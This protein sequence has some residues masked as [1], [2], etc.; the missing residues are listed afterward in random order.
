MI[1]LIA[2]KKTGMRNKLLTEYKN[3]T[4]AFKQNKKPINYPFI[5]ITFYRWSSL[6]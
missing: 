1:A 3:E 2:S 6:P 5:A 4:R